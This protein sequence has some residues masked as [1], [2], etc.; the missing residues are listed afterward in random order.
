[1]AGLAG[2]S[3]ATSAQRRQLMLKSFAVVVCGAML[4]AGLGATPA[5]A[6]E[7]PEQ[8][9]TKVVIKDDTTPKVKKG[10]KVVTDASITTGVKTRLMTDKVARATAIDVDT[11]D[12]V[13]SISGNVPTK[14]DKVR[15]GRLVAHTTGVKSVVNNLTVA[16]AATGTTGADAGSTKVVI[17]DDTT[18]MVKKGARV[19]TDASITSAVKT[20]LMADDLGRALKIDVDTKDGVVTVTGTVPTQADKTKIGD[21][22]AHTTGVKSVVNNLTVQQ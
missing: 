4:C 5:R 6:R 1:M 21:I 9:G 10:A 16:G 14:A 13:V 22:V 8:E 2:I 15:I 12:H 17:K 19:V 18:P 20:R 7:K 3:L 11:K